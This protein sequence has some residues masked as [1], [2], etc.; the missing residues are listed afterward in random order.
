M[1]NVSAWKQIR[2]VLLLCAATAVAA[3]AQVFNNLVSFD[4]TNGAQPR[5]ALIQGANGSLY[6]TTLSGG[7]GSCVY[8]QVC[9]TV[10]DITSSRV[11]KAVILG[12]PYGQ[13]PF[14]SL[15][16][17]TD[18]NYYG[19]TYYG[20]SS[21]LCSP[22]GCGTVFKITP[23][24]TLTTLHVF[25][26]TDGANP[27]YGALIQA[28]DDNF[29]GTT[30]EGGTGVCRNV[31]GAG[32]GTVFKMT[33]AGTLTTLYDFNSTDGA[34]PSGGLIQAI[35][36]NFYGTTQ[37]GGDASC[38]A[39]LGCGTVFE[40]TPQGALTTLH[41]FE[42]VDGA[43]PIGTLIQASDGNLY[44]TTDGGGN[45]N[46]MCGVSCGTAFRITPAGTLTTIYTFCSQ[47][48]CTDGSN[49][50]GLIQATDG[51]FYGTTA[52]GG[53]D[54]VGTIFQL[55]V[56]AALTTL[57]SFDYTDGAYPYAR[58][59]Q[60]TNGTFYGT[61]SYGRKDTCPQ[62]CGTTFSLSMGLGPFV[63]FVRAAGKVG[64]T[65]GILGQGFTG[66]T[67]VSLNGL[68]A[69]FT[70]VSDT[71]IKATVPAGATTGYVTV[72]TP[73]GVLTSNVPF[74]VLP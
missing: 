55:T 48:N 35:D 47:T 7:S 43:Y 18:G 17:G 37:Q 2:A 9:G 29:Y 1:T 3:P 27:S 62:G 39:P 10:F 70:V 13:D 34:H 59:V 46:P 54:G 6:G 45:S 41:T 19:T 22:E 71:F 33:S 72:T 63:T 24:G 12:A 21:A 20:P 16:L 28:A 74:H 53:A 58:P 11:L 14:A 4:G 52:G 15:V 57:H 44:G 23:G 40:L 30:S 73:S 69:N 38:N 68:P 36:G 64:Q 67:S 31:L 32:C 5:A 66:T 61:T 26:S 42:S 25:D 60:A 65:G 8:Y 49:P 51:N 50:P 56:D